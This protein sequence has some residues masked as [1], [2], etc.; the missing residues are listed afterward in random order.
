MNFSRASLAE[1][2]LMEFLYAP[3]TRVCFAVMACL[4][5]A[6]LLFAPL[7]QRSPQKVFLGYSAEDVAKLLN[8]RFPKNDTIGLSVE[9]H[10]PLGVGDQGRN[11]S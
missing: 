3:L 7:L 11:L 10:R 8:V 6:S 4:L 1:K 9:I 5:F 2:E